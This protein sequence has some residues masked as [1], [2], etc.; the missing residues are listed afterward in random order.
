MK[1]KILLVQPHS[2]DILF[3]ASKFLFNSSDYKMVK[4]LTVESGNEKRVQEDIELCELFQVGYENLGLDFEDTS[5]YHYYKVFKHKVFEADNC[6]EVLIDL[7]GKEF[8][9]DIRKKLRKFV[10]SHILAGY[11]I[12]TCVGVGHPMHQFVMEC[13][14]D[15][16]D[17]FYR[18]FPHSY[19]RKTQ[20]AMEDVLSAFKLKEEYFNEE[21]HTLKFDIAYKVYKTQRSL[22]FFEKGYIDKKIAEQFYVLK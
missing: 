19:K 5:Y 13:I 8:L 22:L 6:R 21:E 11:Q 2:D 14:K 1:N 20:G 12:V 17:L 15:L 16:T 18:D 4:V 9:K 10:N 7:Y 3:S